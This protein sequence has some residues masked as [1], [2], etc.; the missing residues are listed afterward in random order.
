MKSVEQRLFEAFVS[1]RGI[2]LTADEVDILIRADDAIGTRITNV[3]G[4]EVGL[5]AIGADAVPRLTTIT[6]HQFK[7]Y[8]K[9]EH[10]E[11]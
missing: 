6:W 7:Q 8:L 4:Y 2:N 5:P 10:N 9:G 1:G 11:S 3:A